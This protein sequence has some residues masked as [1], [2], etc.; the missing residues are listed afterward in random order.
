MITLWRKWI[1]Y[2]VYLTANLSSSL[3]NKVTCGDAR[4]QFQLL[5]FQGNFATNF[6]RSHLEYSSAVWDPRTEKDTEAVQKDLHQKVVGHNIQVKTIYKLLNWPNYIISKHRRLANLIL[7]YKFV[8]G[9]CHSPSYLHDTLYNARHKHSLNLHS[10]VFLLVL[11][12]VC[13]ITPFS[14]QLHVRLWNSLLAGIV[15]SNYLTLLITF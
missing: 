3:Q 4:P 9:F 7:L 2:G 1:V 12:S 10:Q 6:I 13:I 11:L 5:C 15:S 14:H 8:H